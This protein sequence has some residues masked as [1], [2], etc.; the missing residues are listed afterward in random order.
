MRDALPCRKGIA[1][2]S[3]LGR[4]RE[5]LRRLLDFEGAK[6]SIAVHAGQFVTFNAGSTSR[7]IVE[8]STKYEVVSRDSAN[9]S[10]QDAHRKIMAL[11]GW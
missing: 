4:V 8:R 11:H 6:Q 7:A 2:R 3:P 9:T 5:L 1:A 10:N